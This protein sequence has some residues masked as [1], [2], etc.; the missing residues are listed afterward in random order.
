MRITGGTLNGRSLD[1]RLPHGVRPTPARVREALFSML[2]SL[3][4]LEG[5]TVLDAFGGSGILTFEALSRGAYS[6]FVM[7]RG[8]PQV[9]TIREVARRL[10][11]A[12]RVDVRRG[13][14]PR[15]LPAGPFDLAFA[16]PPYASDPGP[17]V[18]ALGRRARKAIVLE[19]SAKGV[20][21]APPE[22]WALARAR[23]Y[24]DTGLAVY[25]PVELAVNADTEGA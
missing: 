21:P 24:G 20:A 12:A 9:E 25:V 10:G 6:A 13:S 11:V 2:M 7:D 19:H 5:S 4:V 14:S 1:A 18:A 16:D 15:D 17:V 22:G 23:T 8:A 3:G